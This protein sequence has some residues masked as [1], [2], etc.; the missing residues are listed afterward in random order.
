MQFRAETAPMP[1]PT[2]PGRRDKHQ[3]IATHR[4]PS[5]RGPAILARRFMH[6]HGFVSPLP[7][8]RYGSDGK[9]E[10]HCEL[11]AVGAFWV[12]LGVVALAAG[13]VC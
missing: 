12:V 6:A 2:D 3:H 4:I 5:E 13:G 10:A 8:S 11:V 7:H 1:R 9:K